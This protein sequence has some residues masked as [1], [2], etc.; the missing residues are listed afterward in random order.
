MIVVVCLVVVDVV[1]LT[2][3]AGLEASGEGASL[4]ISDITVSGV[5]FYTHSR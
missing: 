1:I 3:Y 4:V 2:V 5:R